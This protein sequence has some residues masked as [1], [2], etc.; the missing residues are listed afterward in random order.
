MASLWTG[1]RLITQHDPSL[2]TSDNSMGMWYWLRN[3]VIC[4]NYEYS[5]EV[6][7]T[8]LANHFPFLLFYPLSISIHLYSEISRSYLTA[9]LNVMVA[10]IYEMTLNKADINK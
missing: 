6:F 3:T 10:V 1:S 2:V 9:N 5:A 8:M 7:Q 4:K